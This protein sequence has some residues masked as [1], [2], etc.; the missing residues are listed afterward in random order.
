MTTAAIVAVS[1]INNNGFN[2]DFYEHLVLSSV[3]H[4]CQIFLELAL[5]IRFESVFELLKMNEIISFSFSIR[6]IQ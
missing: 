6:R 5:S 1:G 3:L 4:Q 2:I